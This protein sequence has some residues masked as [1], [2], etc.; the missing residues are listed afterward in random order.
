MHVQIQEGW[1]LYY[2]FL[3]SIILFWQF[4]QFCRLCNYLNRKPPGPS[5]PPCRCSWRVPLLLMEHFFHPQPKVAAV[6]CRAGHCRATWDSL[7]SQVWTCRLVH[8]NQ[9]PGKAS[10]CCIP[11]LPACQQAGKKLQQGC[12]TNLVCTEQAGFAPRNLSQAA[13]KEP[14]PSFVRWHHRCKSC[15]NESH[16]S[17]WFVL[18]QLWRRSFHHKPLSS[19]AWL[20]TGTS[21]L[22]ALRIP[23]N[24]NV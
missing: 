21:F 12:C 11:Q 23:H 7:P 6:G 20:Y 4:D 22:S 2:F 9:A 8:G 19:F 15:G 14:K 3:P 10:H 18:I 13:P 5:R 1:F 16:G 24:H 17:Q